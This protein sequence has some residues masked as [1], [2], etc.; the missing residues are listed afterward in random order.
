MIQ[1]SERLSLAPEPGQ[2]RRVGGERGGQRLDRDIPPQPLVTRAVDLA[3]GS[4]AE[5]SDDFVRS[6]PGVG[7]QRHG[8]NSSRGAPPS[9]AALPRR[10]L[11]E[12]S[13]PPVPTPTSRT[14]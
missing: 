5:R 8:R 13:A 2:P 12:E 14:L 6:E 4:P 9:P 3:H 1:G 10:A 7:R 11:F